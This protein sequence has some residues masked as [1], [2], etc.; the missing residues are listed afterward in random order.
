VKPG[1]VIAWKE[2]STKTV[3]YQL[4]VQEIESKVLPGWLSLD[5]GNMSGQ[6]LSVPTREEIETAIDERLIVAF[7]SR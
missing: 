1:D 6:V 3:P 2:G 4:A 5:R 7:Y